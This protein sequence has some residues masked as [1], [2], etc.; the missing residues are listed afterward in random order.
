MTYSLCP[1]C[2]RHIEAISYEEDGT[3]RMKKTCPEHGNMDYLVEHSAEFYH[4]IHSTPVNDNQNSVIFDVT[5]KCNLNCPHCY[6][7]PDNKSIDKSIPQVIDEIKSMPDSFWAIL[8]GAEPTVREDLSELI[9]E[10]KN[11]FGRSVG[12]LTNGLKFSDKTY[13]KLMVESGLGGPIVLGLSYDNS[14]KVRDVQLEGL[15][16]LVEFGLH[17]MIG[18][19]VKD[20]SCLEDIIRE[21][22]DLYRNKIITVGFDNQVRF[23]FGADIGRTTN[24]PLKTLSKNLNEIKKVCEKLKLSYIEIPMNNTLVHQLVLIEGMPFRVIQWPNVTN[25]VM[26]ELCCGPW[27]RFCEPITNFCHQIILR[28]GFVNKKLPQLD[29][30]PDKYKLFINFSNCEKN[31]E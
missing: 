22:H 5:N 7:M 31:N 27:A 14:K 28:D 13:T 29:Q 15:R 6:H 2:Y 20:Y 4:K 3:I 17:P 30:S 25:I 12:I 21:V 1:I 16:N 11:T 23:R 8:A 9:Q 24:E 19:T 18:I 10:V 26:D